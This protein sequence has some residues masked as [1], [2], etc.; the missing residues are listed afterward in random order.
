MCSA[1]LQY[2]IKCQAFVIIKLLF[3]NTTHQ[4]LIIFQSAYQT[5]PKTSFPNLC[6]KTATMIAMLTSVF[7]LKVTCSV[8]LSQRR[9]IL[10]EGFAV[11]LAPGV[12]SLTI[13]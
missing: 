8:D 5:V 3:K 9:V 10:V 1:K 4:L 2:L 13:Q 6:S 12:K 11:A 7:I